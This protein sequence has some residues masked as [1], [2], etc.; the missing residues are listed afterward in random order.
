MDIFFYFA[1]KFDKIS[2]MKNYSTLFILLLLAGYGWSQCS[3]S[4]NAP[5][6]YLC[7][8]A[9]VTLQAS[10]G[11]AS[12]VWSNGSTGM[13]IS[14]SK[15]GFYTVRATANNNCEA[16]A[17]V[18]INGPKK[19]SFTVQGQKN[20]DTS[21]YMFYNAIK[22]K[23]AGITRFRWVFGDGSSFSSANPAAPADTLMWSNFSKSYTRT[24]VFLPQLI[25]WH[26]SGNCIDTISLDTSAATGVKAP[27]NWS[28][29]VSIILSLDPNS[30]QQV[31]KICSGTPVSLQNQGG[32]PTDIAGASFM[33]HFADP[34]ANPPGSDFV[35][36]QEK[37][38]YR[39]NTSTN[40]FPR[41]IIQCP[42]KPNRIFPWYS[43]IDTINTDPL[44]I[45]SS[46]SI[47]TVKGF[48][49][50][51]NQLMNA[52]RYVYNGGAKVDSLPAHWLLFGSNVLDTLKK[53]K[54]E[55]LFGYGL[56]VLGVKVAIENNTPLGSIKATQKA[57]IEGN[58]P[59]EFSNAST[60]THGGAVFHKWN[61]D[62]AFAPTCTS[63][64]VPNPSASGNGLP[65][66][67]SAIDHINRTLPRFKHKGQTY[68]GRVYCNN[69]TDTLPIH[70]YQTYTNLLRWHKSGFDFPPFDSSATG[71]TKNVSQVTPGGKKLVHPLDQANWGIAQFAVGN[72]GARI[73]TMLGLFPADLQPNTAIVLQ[74][75]I[76]DPIAAYKGFHGYFIPAGTSVDT[77]GFLNP[78]LSGILPDGTLRA[79]YRGNTALPAT[80]LFKDLYEYFFNRSIP[81]AYKA[82]L[83]ISGE[84]G[85]TS[86]DSVLLITGK[87][88]LCGIT[89]ER[90]L[91]PGLLYGAT[92]ID[93]THFWPPAPLRTFILL[94]YDSLLD[95]NDLTPCALDGFVGFDGTHPTSGAVTPGGNVFPPFNNNYNFN[96]M[97]SWV[98]PGQDILKTHYIPS[99]SSAYTWMPYDQKKGKVSIGFIIGTGCNNVGCTGPSIVT[100][101]MWYNNALEF[102]PIDLKF[103][104]SKQS[105][106]S[107]YGK[108]GFLAGQDTTIAFNATTN[109]S[110]QWSRL[111]GKGDVIKPK[112]SRNIPIGIKHA[113]IDWGDGTIEVD[114]FRYNQKD[115]LVNF[116][117]KNYLI[118]KGQYAYAR[119]HY[120]Y[121]QENNA[122]SLKSIQTFPLGQGR[123]LSD[124]WDT[125]YFCY[126]VT[127]SFP[128]QFIQ[129]GAA[130]MDPSINLN[131]LSH[132][133]QTN[134]ANNT[135]SG[136]DI[137]RVYF[138]GQLQNGDYFE[139]VKH[140]T[141]G[142][143]SAFRTET[144]KK[145]FKVNEPIKF[146]DSIFYFNPNTKNLPYGPNRP[147]D[148]NQTILSPKNSF[149]L[150]MLGYPFDSIYVL[151][152]PTRPIPASGSTCPTGYSFRA[153]SPNVCLKN[154]TFFF[155]RIYW[156]YESDGVVDYAGNFPSKTYGSPGKYVVSMITR[157]SV[158]YY[159]TVKQTIEIAN[160]LAF[161]PLPEKLA[162][163][164][165]SVLYIPID[166]VFISNTWYK[167]GAT[168]PISQNQLFYPITQD[169][170][171]YIEASNADQTCFYS[172]TINLLFMN[173]VK[174]KQGNAV[175]KCATGL[176]SLVLE[177][178]LSNGY[179]FQW[180][181]SI[182]QTKLF[183]TKSEGVFVHRLK[184][185]KDGMSCFDSSVTA[186][187]EPLK[188]SPASSNQCVRDTLELKVLSNTA[189]NSLLNIQWKLDSNSN[190]QTGSFTNYLVYPN[191]RSYRSSI[192][193]S[194][195]QCADSFSFFV[196]A[197]PNYIGLNITG[198]DKVKLGDTVTYQVALSV[199]YTYNWNVLGGTILGRSD[200]SMVKVHWNAAASNARV[201]VSRVG[202]ICSEEDSLMVDINSIGL[203]KSNNL[204]SAVLFPNPSSKVLT[205]MA[206][207]QQLEEYKFQIF[208]AEG[209]ILDT[210]MIARNGNNLQQSWDISM[211][212]PGL[213]LL[214]VS[215]QNQTKVYRWIKE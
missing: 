28:T 166:P 67:I 77:A 119:T 135:L 198:N 136:N 168:G 92:K 114:S 167:L 32:L 20:C 83:S 84:L 73:D 146:I 149:R 17:S 81:A 107:I 165:D 31:S 50:E 102:T 74:Q 25:V 143:V 190:Y 23:D 209:R 19:I 39:Y 95:R 65:P 131:H 192:K 62:N 163:C 46:P 133:Y 125:S 41:L 186:Y 134:S 197:D 196:F 85:C 120:V 214:K 76:P 16:Y 173:K 55:N 90:E 44:N 51:P 181:N 33:W 29:H 140:L 24:G 89:F 118:V 122:I 137:H 27:A 82:T 194:Y 117:S 212:K 211:F 64:S 43:R 15:P 112:F 34:A 161:D 86:T 40:V 12:Y 158:G 6:Q 69:S 30:T 148:F 54:P 38:S 61:F 155:E 152:N 126:D 14:V 182:N 191:S 80:S 195:Q 206:Q 111:Y 9:S 35:T 99:N 97:T 123:V 110:E 13:S 100:D 88:D 132:Q 185:T 2:C 105:G 178:T 75:M 49:F 210:G 52:S 3:V 108:N 37:P 45:A 63:F 101:T 78:P 129:P 170:K 208:D 200:S 141:I 139:S 66:Y 176:D 138:Y 104:L 130:V 121:K 207:V 109:T 213:Y 26:N 93:L 5:Q 47:Y 53:V 150:K 156:D 87:P 142:Y 11:F 106:Y 96:P 116:Q 91:G 124:K 1:I 171:Y 10:P 147:L 169:G 8:G 162:I 175:T 21:T 113:V 94:N 58:F 179:Q 18:L 127:R 187:V 57:Q 4:I 98:R 68:T 59:I 42:G 205:F 79:N 160:C 157:D 180:D 115:T 145:A 199:G 203:S 172:D 202:G 193:Q 204:L 60:N 103:N 144:N 71:W 36:N 72:N 201:K 189:F 174:I 154:D 128:P 70:Q 177:P 188:L 48:R 159:D 22:F 153:G 183:I 7:S 56:K 184:I 215:G 164:N 151:A